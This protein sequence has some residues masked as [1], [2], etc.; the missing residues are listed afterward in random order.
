MMMPIIRDEDGRRMAS[1]P[2]SVPLTWTLT[3]ASR[4]SS[5]G[6]RASLADRRCKRTKQASFKGLQGLSDLV[7]AYL[8]EATV[9]NRCQCAA[10]PGMTMGDGARHRRLPKSAQVPKASKVVVSSC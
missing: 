2:G 5:A 8:R 7:P 6:S 1:R 10:R 4:R 3:R 9:R